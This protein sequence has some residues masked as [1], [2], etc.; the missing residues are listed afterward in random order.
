MNTCIMSHKKGLDCRAGPP[1]HARL[2]ILYDSMHVVFLLY[3]LCIYFAFH[4]YQF[5]II[6]HFCIPLFC[7]WSHGVF[8]GFFDLLTFIG[9]PPGFI[10]TSQVQA[11]WPDCWCTLQSQTERTWTHSFLLHQRAT[12]T[13]N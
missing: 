3:V 1:L 13:K 7:H 9:K 6:F 4:L 2:P 11:S 8:V 10:F 12:E 5:C